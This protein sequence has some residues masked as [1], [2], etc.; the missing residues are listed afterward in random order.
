MNDIKTALYEVPVASTD[1]TLE[2]HTDDKRGPA[3]IC[4][5]YRLDGVDYFGGIKFRFPLCTR[6]RAERCCKVWHIEAYDTLM[7]V[8]DSSWVEEMRADTKPSW[9]DKWEMHHYII[10]LDSAGCFEVIADSW[11]SF[12]EVVGTPP[13]SV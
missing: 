12:Q 6:T 13:D 10:Y 4:Y 9:R 1:F 2:A 8:Q 7:E 5:G 3:T 11:S